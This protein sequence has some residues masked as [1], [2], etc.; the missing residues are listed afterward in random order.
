MNTT[1]ERAMSWMI[2]FGIGAVIASVLVMLLQIVIGF[3]WD[4]YR[5]WKGRGK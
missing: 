3:F 5:D 1:I 2:G 4:M